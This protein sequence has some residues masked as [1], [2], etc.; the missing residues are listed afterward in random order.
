MTQPLY[1]IILEV[2]GDRHTLQVAAHH[3]LLHVLREQ[4]NLTGAKQCCEEGECGACTVF[5]DGR[6]VASCLVLAA[7]ADGCRVITIEGLAQD[8]QLDPLQEAFLENGAVQCGFCIPGM[9]MAGKYLLQQNPHPSYD[10][11]L[12]GLSGNLCRCGGYSRIAQAVLS[13]ADKSAGSQ[14]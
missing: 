10:E 9:I 5:L 6:A 8:E 13:A 3:S 7:E 12:E 14:P 4:L 11:V 2:N 1:P